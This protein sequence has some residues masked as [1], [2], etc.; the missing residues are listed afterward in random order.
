MSGRKEEAMSDDLVKRLRDEHVAASRT[1]AADHIEAL[2]AEN[3]RLRDALH[4][5][6][7][8]EN[9][10]IDG[11]LDGNSGNYTGGPAKSALDSTP[12]AQK[13]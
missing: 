11:P 1:E 9:W 12:G 5:Y 3:A 6:T 4:F 2:E 10:R 7:V 13:D 8:P